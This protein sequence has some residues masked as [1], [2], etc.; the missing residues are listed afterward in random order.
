MSLNSQ[1]HDFNQFSPCVT[2]G[3][4]ALHRKVDKLFPLLSDMISS[5]DFTDQARL[6]EI[7]LKHQTG[8]QSSLN[9]RAMKYATSLSNTGISQGSF[10]NNYWYGVEYFC[11]VRDLAGN[12]DKYA[13]EFMEKMKFFQNN[14]LAQEGAQIVLTCDDEMYTSLKDEAFYGLLNLKLQSYKPWVPQFLL[15]VLRGE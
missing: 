1:I 15:P 8:L 2:L 12:F 9:R 7:V 5:A 14:F 6:K 11:K 4:K 13:S 3:G 10:V